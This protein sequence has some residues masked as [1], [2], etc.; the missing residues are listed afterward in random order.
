MQVTLSV[1]FI[2]IKLLIVSPSGCE[3]SPS[4]TIKSVLTPLCSH[5]QNA[6]RAI[7]PAHACSEPK[8]CSQYSQIDPSKCCILREMAW[9]Q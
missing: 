9:F 8:L 2:C 5:H 3:V 1:W 4:L 7:L 6:S